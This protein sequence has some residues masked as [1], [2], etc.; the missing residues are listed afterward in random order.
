MGGRNYFNTHNEWQNEKEVA[1]FRL[2]AE[3]QFYSC[4]LA[5]KYFWPITE[6][7][8]RSQIC[9]YL[10]IANIHNLMVTTGPCI[11]Q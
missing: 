9:W 5:H 2:E 4:R 1:T 11:K 10:P 3:S 6:S 8:Q 7:L